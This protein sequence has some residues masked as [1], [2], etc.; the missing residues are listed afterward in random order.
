MRDLG[1]SRRIA[2]T[3]PTYLLALGIVAESD[4]VAVVPKQL[5]DQLGGKLGVRAVPLPLA[6]GRDELFLHVPVI[7]ETEPGS[8]W[9]R[10]TIKSLGGSI[11]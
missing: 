3:V 2:L 1:H 10:K 11:S 9:L 7:A 5:T 6:P 4:L 8:M